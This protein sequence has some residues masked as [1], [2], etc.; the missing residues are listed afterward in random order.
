[1]ARPLPEAPYPAR[2]A[3]NNYA[4]EGALERAVKKAWARRA[5]LVLF[6][7]NGLN[8]FALG[9]LIQVLLV[10]YAGWGHVAS[11]IAQTVAS[12]QISFLL[13][14]YVT[15]RDRD[16]A[17]LPALARFNLQQ[18]TVTGLGMAGYAALEQLGMN[19]IVANVAVTA[20][21]TPVSFLS[22]HKWS[23]AARRER[24][25]G[26]PPVPAVRPRPVRAV[27]PGPGGGPGGGTGSWSRALPLLL[28]SSWAWP[29]ACT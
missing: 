5:Q 8:V 16:V 28:C 6:A 19:Y 20:A 13:S 9:L 4:R 24:V 27:R 29:W 1:M 12:V 23:L 18:L 10:R 11:Y 25:T 22:S 2:P 15:W 14:R 7:V 21:L 26:P 17:T 3:V